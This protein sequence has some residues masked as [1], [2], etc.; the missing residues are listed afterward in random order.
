[1]HSS[2]VAFLAPPLVADLQA[3]ATVGREGRFWPGTV[4]MHFEP[5]HHRTTLTQDLIFYQYLKLVSYAASG[6]EAVG[7]VHTDCAREQQKAGLA[8]L[9]QVLQRHWIS[10]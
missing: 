6:N 5:Q 4:A 8:H 7:H 10:V 9:E 1:M 3:P 2:P